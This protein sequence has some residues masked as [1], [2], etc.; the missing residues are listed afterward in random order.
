MSDALPIRVMVQE[1][2]DHVNLS[3]PAATPVA[4]VKRQALGLAR[5]PGDPGE[6][7]VK[8]RG[9]E[10]LKETQTLGEAGIAPNAALI[11]LPRRRRPV[12]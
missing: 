5:V 10:L 4:E 7:L 3:V 9:A 12:R 1:A 8:Y 2:W 11:V 6:F